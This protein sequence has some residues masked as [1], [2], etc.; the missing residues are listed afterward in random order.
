MIVVALLCTRAVPS[1]R[2]RVGGVWLVGPRV[3]RKDL[4]VVVSDGVDTRDELRRGH[5]SVQRLKTTKAIGVVRGKEKKLIAPNR[6]A[7][8]SAKL[9]VD[10]P[11]LDDQELVARVQV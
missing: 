4:I 9:V 6:T 1:P 3:K 5:L 8:R 11:W 10:E 7:E 2:N